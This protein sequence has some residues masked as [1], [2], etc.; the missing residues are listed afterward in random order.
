MTGGTD[1]RAYDVGASTDVQGGIK[2]VIGRLD[3]VIKAREAQV[4]A[5]MSDFTAEGVSDDYHAK[6]L[7]WKNASQEVKNIIQLL[8]A[9]LAK[10]DAT[11]HQTLQR[12]RTAVDN[13][14]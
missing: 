7:R 4:T 6:E 12:A 2:A 9:T 3:Q 14:G 10:N 5:V 8:N 1:R 13:I 11:A